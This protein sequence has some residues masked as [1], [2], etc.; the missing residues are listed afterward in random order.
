MR[1]PP[2]IMPPES[3]MQPQAI[4][5][6]PPATAPADLSIPTAGWQSLG[7]VTSWRDTPRELFLSC[8]AAEVRLTL[9]RASIVRVRVASRGEFGR[10][11]SWAVIPD[12]APEI[13]TWTVAETPDALL[14]TAE[15]VRVRVDRNPCRISFLAPD[16]RAVC[17]ETAADGAAFNGPAL[18]CW[19]RLHGDDH[20]FGLG[21]KAMPFDKRGTSLVNWN[22]DE[23]GYEGWSDPLYQS[24]PILIVFNPGGSYGLFFDNAWRSWFDLGKTSRSAYGFGAD[25]GELNYYYV[26]G[27]TAADVMQRYARLVGTMPL[28]PLWALGYQQSRYS[29]T[30]HTRV[31]AL[32]AEFRKRRVPCDTIY[33]DIDYMDGYRCFTWHPKHFPKP[34]RLMS[35]LAKQGFKVVTILDP[36]IK[37]DPD[38]DVYRG[39]VAGDH[40]C[41]DENGEVYVGKVWPGDS[42]FPDFTRAATRQWWGSQYRGLVDAGVRGFW[43]DMNEPADFSRPEKTLPL[44]VRFDNEG[45]PADHRAAHN[46]YGMQMARATFEGVRKLRPDQRPFVLT[47]A[48]YAGVQ[49][50]AAVW[51]GDNLSRWHHLQMSV[52]MMLNLGVSGYVFCGADIGGFMGRPDAELFARWLQLGIFYPLCRAH[53][54]GWE[55]RTEQ[56]PWSFGKQTEAVNRRTIE[57][58]YRL[59][60][61]LYTEMRHAAETGLPVMRP[62]FMD[63]PELPD[64]WRVDSD[65]MFGRQLL[66]AP[67]LWEKAETRWL[68]LPPGTWYQFDNLDPARPAVRHDGAVEP[69]T[70]ANVPT[71][72]M[73]GRKIELAVELGA[74]PIFAK[75]GAIVPM[76][77][78]QQFT[79]ERPLEE[80]TLELFPGDGRGWFYNDD[81]STCAYRQGE[82]T[83]EEYEQATAADSR[84]LRLAARQGDVRFAP[85][86]YL[87]RFEAA[88]AAPTEVS[89]NDEPLP[90]KSK[91]PA[92]GR[93]AA[94]SWLQNSKTVVVRVSALRPGDSVRVRSRPRVRS[95]RRRRT[96]V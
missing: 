94:W 55:G 54:V 24:H 73:I 40:F 52:P 63:F 77:E 38:Y 58:R 3:L 69:E 9:E 30:P 90:R 12:A 20:C 88:D 41:R 45:Q 60:P 15:G 79:D 5:R 46:V 23:P 21:E 84:M 64:V 95:G 10:D 75:A 4:R 14:V 35:H 86:S 57:L 87:L 22:T 47:R 66:I 80:L 18:A 48:G 85:K 32:A 91:L 37:V 16:G 61:Y 67:V 44:S 81:G 1:Q 7:N 72:R 19:K 29:Y 17:E 65:F 53:F 93:E 39:G 26:P 6:Y 27:P 51:T 31:R 50:Y 89:F 43:N 42:A 56:D 62:L 78:V 76:R 92:A 71:G 28:P 8:G 68:R 74:I 70:I 49:R 96:R 2:D 36:G 82:F 83:F 11:F 34:A 59:L 25:G 33:L 13:A